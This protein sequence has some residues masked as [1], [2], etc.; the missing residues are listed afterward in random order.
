MFLACGY[1]VTQGTLVPPGYRRADR[2][3]VAY[4]RGDYSQWQLRDLDCLR[5]TLGINVVRI[6]SLSSP[7][8]CRTIFRSTTAS[9]GR[10]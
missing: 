2:T 3:T 1:G 6:T 8:A 5:D 7:T 9:R 4:V 10:T